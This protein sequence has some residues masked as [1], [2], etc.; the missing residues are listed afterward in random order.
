MPEEGTPTS[1]ARKEHDFTS[2]GIFSWPKLD[3]ERVW[4]AH[5][6]LII[7]MWDATFW[8]LW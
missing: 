4:G 6:V 3:L 1:T 5:P 8:S 7:A 2:R